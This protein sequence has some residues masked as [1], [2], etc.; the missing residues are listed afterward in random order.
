[1]EKKYCAAV[2]I[3]S[4]VY[5]EFYCDENLSITEK[6]NIARIRAEKT[7][8]ARLPPE[9]IAMQNLSETILWPAR[10]NHE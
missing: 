8:E 1:M 9:L 2:T 6:Q 3:K 10:D 4:R 5:V 7:F